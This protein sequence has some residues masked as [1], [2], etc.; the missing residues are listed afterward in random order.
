MIIQLHQPHASLD[1]TGFGDDFP[2]ILQCHSWCPIARFST[3][4][5]SALTAERPVLDPSKPNVTLGFLTSFKDIEKLLIAGAVPL[6]V[7]LVNEDPDLLPTHN[8]KFIAYDSGMPT[9]H[10]PSKDDT[11][12]R[13]RRDWLHWFRWKLRA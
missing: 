8:M 10:R 9:V 2:Y 3:S 6:A 11:D 1:H 7:D 4:P 5:D 12:E 13:R